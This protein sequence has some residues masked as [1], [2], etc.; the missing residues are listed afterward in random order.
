MR[1][2]SF[3]QVISFLVFAMAFSMIAIGQT[4]TPTPKS[5]NNDEG[6]VIKV[7][8]R[9]VVVPVAVTDANGQPVMGLKP[10]DFKIVEE[11]KTQKVDSLGAAEAV[12]L[13]IALLFDVSASTDAM[14]RFE[15]DTAAKFL[16]D[17]LRPNDRATIYTIGAA[18]VLVQ[19]RDTADK[20]I[21]SIKSI[22]ATKEQTAFYD[23]ISAASSYLRNN[24]PDGTRRVFL[25]IS[26][27]E[28]TNSTRVAE[29]L[30]EGYRK[31]GDKVNTLDSK[32]LYQLTVA[33][34]DQAA[35]QER[36][37]VSKSIQDTDAVFY[38]INPA[39]S[40]YQLNSISMFGQDNM[41]SFASE[42]GGTAFLPKFLP[43]DTK[44]ALQNASNVRKNQ[45]TLDKIF[46]Q[47]ESE[48][49]AQYL[50][51]YYPETDYPAGRYVKL[52]VGLQNPAGRK[53][54]ARDGYY[55]KK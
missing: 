50:V 8:S 53:V 16:K 24:A 42:T 1:Q 3:L 13:E 52:E 23:T 33:N 10:D 15:Q 6:Q 14:F 25:V 17:V 37:R 30:Q 41:Q 27:G 22:A 39:G 32:T 47:I 4:A 21:E 55:V 26:D 7:D 18:P 35:L 11:G 9:L 45:D 49:R 36:K 12:P 34:R 40:S 28:D 31:L 48:L 46:R 43:I 19:P 44:D 54:R 5:L 2:K 38:S 29:A 20:S 51:Q